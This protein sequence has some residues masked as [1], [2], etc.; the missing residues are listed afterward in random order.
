MQVVSG[1]HNIWCE[2]HQ[3]FAKRR[4]RRRR[5]SP[6]S[7][8]SSSTTLV[9][10][11]VYQSEAREQL[12]KKG[13]FITNSQ[14][15]II[16]QIKLQLLKL[17]Q[18]QVE[19][20]Q[21]S[22]TNSTR[23]RLA[24]TTTITNTATY[25]NTTNIDTSID[26]NSNNADTNTNNNANTNDNTN[27]AATTSLRNDNINHQIALVKS[28]ISRSETLRIFLQNVS[29]N[30]NFKSD[31]IEN[32]EISTISSYIRNFLFSPNGTFVSQKAEI[33]RGLFREQV[34]RHFD[35][36]ILKEAARINNKANQVGIN[37]RT[38]RFFFLY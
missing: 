24:T 10:H 21:H 35:Y 3:D 38:L 20:Y 31:D 4:R 13:I 14:D 16:K 7:S 8:S 29:H 11:T 15:E 1:Q 27:T 34:I 22:I 12:R 32:F 2:Q 28:I 23:R 26:T 17:K 33:N 19:Y 18:F 25:N 9:N 30:Y 6:P 5:R 37:V 36:W